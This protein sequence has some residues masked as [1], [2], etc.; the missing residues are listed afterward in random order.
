[1]PACSVLLLAGE[2]EKDVFQV[3]FNGT[4]LLD[5]KAGSRNRG[6]NSGSGD[7]LGVIE[8][9]QVVCLPARVE[10]P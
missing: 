7:F 8:D 10:I 2:V 1:M 6:D 4:D 5:N 9:G 3:G